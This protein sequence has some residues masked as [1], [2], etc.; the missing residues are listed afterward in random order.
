MET[1]S[2][3][4]TNVSIDESG[5]VSYLGGRLVKGILADPKVSDSEAIA[6]VCQNLPEGQDDYMEQ[7]A[8]KLRRGELEPKSDSASESE[9]EPGE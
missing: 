9:S 4:E 3:V 2:D 6:A 7:Q 1:E 8:R 5:E